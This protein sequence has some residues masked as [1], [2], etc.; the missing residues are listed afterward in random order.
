MRFLL[1]TVFLALPIPLSPAPPALPRP[2]NDSKCI[3]SAQ[4]KVKGVTTVK[5]Q[6]WRRS[7][8]S[9]RTRG[10]RL[11][12]LREAVLCVC[13]DVSSCHSASGR[14]RTL[15]RC[16]RWKLEKANF[17]R[18]VFRCLDSYFLRALIPPPAPPLPFVSRTGCL[19]QTWTY[20]HRS[21]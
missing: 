20:A 19:D 21:V 17:K 12:L 3:R 9:Q 7:I 8:A 5:V 2:I 4:D 11:P 13:V 18:S 6:P 1:P 14:L 15:R 16:S 10:V